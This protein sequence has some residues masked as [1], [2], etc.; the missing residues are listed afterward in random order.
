MRLM[1][2]YVLVSVPMFHVVQKRFHYNRNKKTNC[3][4]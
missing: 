4:D 3:S 2:Y 1:K